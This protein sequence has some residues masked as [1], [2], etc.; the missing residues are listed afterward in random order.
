MDETTQI[1]KLITGL[2][3]SNKIKKKNK[4]KLGFFE[5]KWAPI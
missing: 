5:G 3:E 2:T 4:N 1:N